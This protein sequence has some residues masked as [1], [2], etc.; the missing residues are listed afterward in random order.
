MVH[1][2]DLVGH[3]HGFVLVVGDIDRRCV[4]AVVQFSQ[5][6]NHDLAEFRI[7]GAEWLV[8]QKAFRPPDDR[9]AKGDALPV[10]TG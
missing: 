1:Y 6:M 2:G 3:G 4:H 7:E 9:P 10:A 8:H 5:F